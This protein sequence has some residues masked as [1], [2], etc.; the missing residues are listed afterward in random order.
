MKELDPESLKNMNVSIKLKY[1]LQWGLVIFINIVIFW[2]LPS[3]SNL[4]AQ[5][6]LYWDTSL[7]ENK[8]CNEVNDNNYLITFYLL[9]WIYFYLSAIQICYGYPELKKGNFL[10]KNSTAINRIGFQT[11]RAIPF[12][13]ELKIFSDWSFTRT[14]LDVFQWIKFDN[15]YGDLFIAKCINKGYV[16]HKL[17]DPISKLIKFLVGIL[18]T[19]GLVAI[20]AGPMLLFSTLNPIAQ[21]NP[22]TGTILDM[23]I[24]VNVTSDGDIINKYGIFHNDHVRR[25]GYISDALYT[26]MNLGNEILTRK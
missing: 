13:L 22:I 16:A 14:S 23:S 20:I 10:M 6:H 19:L 9:Y 7:K 18:G 2:F 15:I 21:D 24:E 4:A 5:N 8:K 3:K 25:I 11:F 12:L 26:Q 1:Y 17:G